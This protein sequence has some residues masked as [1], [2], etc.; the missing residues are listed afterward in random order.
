MIAFRAADPPKQKP[1]S[2]NSFAPKP[3]PHPGPYHTPFSPSTAGPAASCTSSIYQAFFGTPSALEAWLLLGSSIFFL[4]LS[5]SPVPSYFYFFLLPT[6][7]FTW[8]FCPFLLGS[9]LNLLPTGPRCCIFRYP[10]APICLRRNS[11]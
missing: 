10:V 2:V 5:Y 8:V 3:I 1:P 6:T 11:L 7:P 4:C 9:N